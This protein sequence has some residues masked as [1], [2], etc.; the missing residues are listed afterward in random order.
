MGIAVKIC[1]IRDREALDAATNGGADYVGFVFYPPSPRSIEP[2]TASTLA[3]QTTAKCV[4]VFVNPTD[5]DLVRVL[6]RVKLEY[7]QLHGSE[8]PD[9]LMEIRRLSG[10]PLIKAVPVSGPDDIT[11]AKAYEEIADMLLFDAKPPKSMAGALPG[12]NALR[13]DWDLLAYAAF[14]LPWFLSGGLDAAV[15]SEAIR[16]SG[17]R[18]V[19][20]SSGV[21][22]R[23][24][25]KSPIKIRAF[26]KAAK[27]QKE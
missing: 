14:A 27:T 5:E 10:L 3:G 22:D 11:A 17:A 18:A 16:R 2:E 4:G 1:G 9:R 25:I 19:D 23:P 26:L 8:S 13:F 6:T 24:G 12:G 7:I 20:V 21:E 15:V